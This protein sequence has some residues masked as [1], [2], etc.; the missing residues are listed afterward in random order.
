MKDVSDWH[1]IPYSVKKIVKAC[2]AMIR[3]IVMP[4][5]KFKRKQGYRY[6]AWFA[7]IFGIFDV[8]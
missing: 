4:K 7:N 2:I 3:R 8:K 5:H 1:K 6:D